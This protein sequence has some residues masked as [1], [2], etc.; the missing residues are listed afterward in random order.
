MATEDR[1][2]VIAKELE[3]IQSRVPSI[4]GLKLIACVPM[5]VQA[6]ITKNEFKQVTA[7][8]QFPP[9][10][11]HEPI[12]IQMKSR[13][14]EQ[15]FTD[16]LEKIC[17]DEAKKWIGARQ[18][19]VIL[20]FIRTFLEENSLC[21]CSEEIVYIKRELIKDSDEIK[22]K[23]K[24]SQIFLKINQNNYFMNLTVEVPDIYPKQQIKIELTETNFPDLLRV[25]F[26]AQAK[27]L[28]RQC[29]TPPLLKNTN[30]PFEVKPS[31]KVVCNYLIKDCVKRYPLENCPICKSF[32][33][34]EDPKNEL[35]GRK[36]Q[37]E[38]VY[39]GHLFHNGCLDKYMKTP[40]FVGGKKCPACDKK[41]YHEKWRVSA[42][43]ME[44]RWAHKQAKQR[45]LEE[46]KD[47]MND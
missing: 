36:N 9:R 21:V 41:I 28:A 7:N 4:D 33:L 16:K 17:E 19:L 43:V 10:Y 14:L 11:P 8:I 18:V 46:V 12:M 38:R 35:K 20:K 3:D 47:F 39:C 15:K 40:P 44:N 34:A 27:E 26:I 1:D 30:Q 6:S 31:L 25:N 29:V 22:L 42:E 13:R 32:V 24:T 37:I 5:L 45:E 23:Q 2:S